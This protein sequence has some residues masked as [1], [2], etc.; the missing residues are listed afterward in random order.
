MNRVE[1]TMEE[2]EEGIRKLDAKELWISNSN[3]ES[4]AILAMFLI[5]IAILGAA[6]ETYMFIKWR[7]IKRIIKS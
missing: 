4:L 7:I 3:P 2:V 6:I 5:S 1:R